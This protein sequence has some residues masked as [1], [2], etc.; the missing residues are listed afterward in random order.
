[1][2]L[3]ELNHEETVVLLGFM[4]VIIQADGEFTE[5]EREQVARVREAV[6]AERFQTAMHEAAQR[7]EDNNDALKTATKAITRPEARKV[8][9]ALLVDVAESDSVTS[10]EEKPLRWLES[11][12]SLPRHGA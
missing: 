6:G 2:H 1:M 5:S 8:I 12:W 4:R 11:W 3:N 10:E 9:H 7:F